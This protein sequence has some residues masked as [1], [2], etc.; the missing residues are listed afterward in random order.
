MTL[1]EVRALVAECKFDFDAGPYSLE[2]H[3]SDHDGW[4]LIGTYVEPDIITHEPEKQMTRR[5]PLSPH[6]VKSEVV[7][8]CFKCCMTS[9]EHRARETFTYRGRRIYGP[10]FDVE[11]LWGI[12]SK[13][14]VRPT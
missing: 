14:D 9:M 11:A 13:V 8:T 10:H 6:M 7:A 4:Y 12:A 2:V 3:T 1:D 5:W